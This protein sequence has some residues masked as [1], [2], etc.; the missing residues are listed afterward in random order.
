MR[1]GVTYTVT[2]RSEEFP[3]LPAGR[4]APPP[5][6]HFRTT[7]PLSII[8]PQY[9][10]S[11]NLHRGERA[12]R[13]ESTRAESTR[14]ENTRG[15]AHFRTITK[16]P[17]KADVGSRVAQIQESPRPEAESPGIGGPLELDPKFPTSTSQRSYMVMGFKRH[18]TNA[19]RGNHFFDLLMS[20]LRTY[21]CFPSTSR[22]KNPLK[23]G[24]QQRWEG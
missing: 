4:P 14:A 18:A 8:I 20:Y 9:R 3:E 11:C 22:G 10:T 19:T 23:G 21:A 2:S 17:T 16:R 24:L 1:H 15:V 12:S 13:P 6:I 5:V 7:E